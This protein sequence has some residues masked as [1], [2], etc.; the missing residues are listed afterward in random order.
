MQELRPYRPGRELGKQYRVHRGCC[1]ERDRVP[2]YR[3]QDHEQCGVRREMP[4]F[5]EHPCHA[6][7]KGNIHSLLECPIAN[8]PPEPRPVPADRYTPL[9]T[10]R[11]GK[12]EEAQRAVYDSNDDIAKNLSHEERKPD[13][14]H[15]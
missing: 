14:L 12:G 2:K 9:L 15:Y 5:S 13:N 11:L 10:F 7:F 3:A 8:P 6:A 4:A 1:A